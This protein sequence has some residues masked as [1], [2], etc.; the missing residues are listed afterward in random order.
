MDEGAPFEALLDQPAQIRGCSV[1]QVAQEILPFPEVGDVAALQLSH[2]V[3][4]RLAP[5]PAHLEV[6]DVGRVE[7]CEGEPVEPPGREGVEIGLQDDVAQVD[8]PELDV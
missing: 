2:R 8:L 6:V 7:V 3:D 1:L 5:P 4:Q